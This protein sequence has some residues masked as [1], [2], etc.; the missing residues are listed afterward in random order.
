MERV[1]CHNVFQYLETACEDLGFEEEQL[2]KW[3]PQLGWKNKNKW[4]QGLQ[5]SLDKDCKHPRIERQGGRRPT[6]AP[7]PLQGVLWEAY[8]SCHVWIIRVIANRLCWW[9][10]ERLMFILGPV[11]WQHMWI[12]WLQ[13]W[14]A[15]RDWED[16]GCGSAAPFYTENYPEFDTEW[17]L[18]QVKPWAIGLR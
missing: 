5:M 6:W 18:L 4:N 16:L 7:L 15:L 13:R 14:F 3:S 17:Y 11:T 10:W 8:A 12:S 9:G 1:A 2:G